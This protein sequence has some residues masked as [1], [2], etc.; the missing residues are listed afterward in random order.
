MWSLVAQGEDCGTHRRAGGHA[1]I[2]EKHGPASDGGRRAFAAVEASTTG[3]F[4]LLLA[5]NLVDQT[6]AEPGLA[7]DSLV[8]DLNAPVGNSPECQLA[9]T[10]YAQLTHKKQV[11][12]GSEGLSGFEGDRYAPPQEA[13]HERIY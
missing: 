8:E 10:G 7:D 13:K 12:V 11:Q 1:V 3:Q 5:C 9:L 4:M 2:D 6:L